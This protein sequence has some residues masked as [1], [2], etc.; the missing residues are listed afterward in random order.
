MRYELSRDPDLDE[1]LSVLVHAVA[2]PVRYTILILLDDVKKL[3][4]LQDYF[5]QWRQHCEA[6]AKGEIQP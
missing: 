3:R 1:A 5:S 2:I 6:I 4:G